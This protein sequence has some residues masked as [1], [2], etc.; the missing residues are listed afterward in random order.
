MATFQTIINRARRTLLE[1]AEVS[2]SFWTDAELLEHGINA[3][4]DLWKGVIDVYQDHFLRINTTS[5][6][7]VANQSTLSGVPADCFRVKSIEPRVPASYPNMFFRPRD[8]GHTTFIG[9]RAGAAQDP[10]GSVFLYDLV[11]PGPP[12]AA[13]DVWIGPQS[14][15]NVL[16]TFAYISAVSDSLTTA[17]VNPIPG[18]TDMAVQAWIVAHARAKERE[19]RSPDPEWLAIYGTEKANLIVAVTPRQEDEPDITEDLFGEAFDG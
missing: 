4:K 18:E 2:D 15:S 13:P 5:V 16:L 8:W 10:T 6:S 12:V 11:G 14:S 3:A 17:S 7:V 1:V 19:D 9:A